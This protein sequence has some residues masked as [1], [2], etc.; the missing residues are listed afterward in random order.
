MDICILKLRKI[1]FVNIGR[2]CL[3]LGDIRILHMN[4][5]QLDWLIIRDLWLRSKRLYT[6]TLVLSVLRKSHIMQ[7]RLVSLHRLL[8]HK[9][10]LSVLHKVGISEPRVGLWVLHPIAD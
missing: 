5:I 10:T 1:N 7:L 3:L 2:V 4:R 6:S 9:L 8:T